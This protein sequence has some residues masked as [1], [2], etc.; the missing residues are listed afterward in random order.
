M[1]AADAHAAP[2]DDC[3]RSD[4]APG[5]GKPDSLLKTNKRRHWF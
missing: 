4:G 1:I 2:E 3:R 5:S